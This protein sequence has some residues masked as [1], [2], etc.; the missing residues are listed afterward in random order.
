[1]AAISAG[2]AVAAVERSGEREILLV[3]EPR[4]KS[5]K[6]E[7]QRLRVSG[8]KGEG[9]RSWRN[10]MKVLEWEGESSAQSHYK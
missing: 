10:R 1:M 9:I 3:S 6:V 4:E 8:D 2:E 7:G 5:P